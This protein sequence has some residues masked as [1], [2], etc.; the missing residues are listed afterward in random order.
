MPEQLHLRVR[1]TTQRTAGDPSDL[2][3]EF[4]RPQLA[5]RADLHEH[6]R[7]LLGEGELVAPRRGKAGGLHDEPDLVGGRAAARL[8]APRAD[9]ASC[10]LRV[11]DRVEDRVREPS[12][13]EGASHRLGFDTHLKKRV[14]RLDLVGPGADLADDVT[15][16]R[17]PSGPHTARGHTGHDHGRRRTTGARSPAPAECARGRPLPLGAR[18]RA[19]ALGGRARRLS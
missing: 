2:Q 4:G 13:L 7:L 19:L 6:L 8:D 11:Q 1:D 14:D 9:C 10:A 3:G 5:H 15:D 12:A 18:R 17:M 16:A